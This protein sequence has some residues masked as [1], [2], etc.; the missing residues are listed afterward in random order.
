[1]ALTQPR[2]R[3]TGSLLSRRPQY[4]G[5]GNPIPGGGGPRNIQLAMEFTPLEIV[6]NSVR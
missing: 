6:I 4:V 1:M 5:I 2:N 3:G